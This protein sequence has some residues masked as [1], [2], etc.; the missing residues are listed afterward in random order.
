VILLYPAWAFDYGGPEAQRYSTRLMQG[1]VFP[2][3]GS[4]V[5]T[6]MRWVFL[7]GSIWL[8]PVSKLLPHRRRRSPAAAYREMR[9]ISK[10]VF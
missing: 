9:R 4:V 7:R 3:D 2:A 1:D 8:I 10:A 5:L 6:V